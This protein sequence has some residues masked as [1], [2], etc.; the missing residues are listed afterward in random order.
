MYQPQINQLGLAHAC[1]CNQACILLCY[2]KIE[3]F[4]FKDE[5]N[6]EYEI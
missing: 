4:R 1:H 6:Y 5:N 3:T 2:F